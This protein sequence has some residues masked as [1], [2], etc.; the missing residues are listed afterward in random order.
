MFIQS[1]PRIMVSLNWE[2]QNRVTFNTKF[3]ELAQQQHLRPSEIVSVLE[4]LETPT[5]SVLR[6]VKVSFLDECR[7]LV[8]DAVL[9]TA[10]VAPR[11]LFLSKSLIERVR[12]SGTSVLT[13]ATRHNIPEDGILHSHRRENVKSCITLTGCAL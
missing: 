13:R 5:S 7:L 11:F 2:L 6:E 1:E 9:V 4:L 12:S 3:R 8:C 10:N